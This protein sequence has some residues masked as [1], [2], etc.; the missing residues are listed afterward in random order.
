VCVV[1]DEAAAVAGERGLLERLRAGDGQACEELVRAHTGRLLAATRKMLRHEE[2][3]RDAVQ[4]TFL[5]AFKSLPS[6]AG[7]SSLGTWL[8]RI[9]CNAALMK[10]RKR[11]RRPERSIEELL[12]RFQDDGHHLEPQARWDDRADLALERE[13]TRAFVRAAIEELPEIYR[14]VLL[15]RDIAGQGTEEVAQTLSCTTNAVKIRL[16]RAHQALRTLLDARFRESNR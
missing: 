14:T 7:D 6:F 9:A 13:E 8:Y 11:K 4:E 12:P 15:L 10:L 2:D 16:H 3:A 1:A 5:S